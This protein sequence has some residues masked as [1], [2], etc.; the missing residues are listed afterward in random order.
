MVKMN[1]DVMSIRNSKFFYSIYIFRQLIMNIDCEKNIENTDNR[2]D[3]YRGYTQ[4]IM[5]LQVIQQIF[6]EMLIGGRK[7]V[8]SDMFFEVT[9]IRT[10]VRTDSSGFEGLLHEMVFKKTFMSQEICYINGNG[11]RKLCTMSAYIK[12]FLS[13]VEIENKNVTDALSWRHQLN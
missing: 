12:E 4:K 11:E 5:I 6:C 7:F 1:Q 8:N 9:N 10:N 13:I 3:D 2:K